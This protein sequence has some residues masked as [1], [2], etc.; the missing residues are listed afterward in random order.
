MKFSFVHVGAALGLVAALAGCGG[1]AQYTVKGTIAGLSNSG[2]VL[3]NG[4]DTVSVPAGATSFSFSRQISY[5]DSFDVEV[6]T[7]PAHMTCAVD[8]VSN[9]GSAGLTIEINALVSCTQNTY[10]L[11]GQFTGLTAA[12]DGTAR[13]ITLTNG[14]SSITVSSASGTNG[15]GEFS[16]GN[17]PDGSNY[18]VTWLDPIKAGL[19][20]YGV[21]CTVSN[22]IG[23]INEANVSNLLVACTPR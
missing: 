9:R 6:K 17:L 22:G 12:A 1:K 8:G 23:V 19:T 10:T 13:L 3:S 21:K 15:A 11:G 5:G 18:G 14:S 16:F 7:P 4:S 20:D 2:L